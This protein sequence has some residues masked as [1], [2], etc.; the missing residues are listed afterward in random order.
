MKVVGI[1]GGIGSGK[2]IICRIFKSL[3]VPVYNADESV[4][5]LY[6]RHPE[7][8]KRIGKE[9]S[10]NALDKNGKIN[11]KNLAEIVFSNPDKL[12]ILNGI[13]HPAVKEDFE[14][15]LSNH[16]N[17]SYVLKEAAILFESGAYKACDK[18]ITVTSP[19]EL[20]ISRVRERDHKSRAETE[21]IISK[22]LDDAERIKKSDFIIVNDETQLILPQVLKIHLALSKL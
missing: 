10:E 2:S 5:S 18:I 3:G 7:I 20:R 9:I 15:W 12:K 6:E 8:T 14:N 22:Q 19:I 21:Q 17:F 13:V 16:K 4:H 11:R 1:T